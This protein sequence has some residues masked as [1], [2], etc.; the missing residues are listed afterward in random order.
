[1]AL[2]MDSPAYSMDDL[3]VTQLNG[4]NACG[5]VFCRKE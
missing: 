5:H 4:D 1:M 3:G 2:A